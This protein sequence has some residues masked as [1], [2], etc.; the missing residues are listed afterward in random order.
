MYSTVGRLNRWWTVLTGFDSFDLDAGA[1]GIS[2]SMPFPFL[3]VGTRDAPRLYRRPSDL[4]GSY[5]CGDM[6]AGGR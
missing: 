4:G 3:P 1:V 6:F 5:F 2:R